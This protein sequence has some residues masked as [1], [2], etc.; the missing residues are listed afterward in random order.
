MEEYRPKLIKLSNKTKLCLACA[1]IGRK[2]QPLGELNP[3]VCWRIL[4]MKFGYKLCQIP[5]CKLGECWKEHLKQVE[6]AISMG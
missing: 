3:N 5:L 4:E 1:A 2:R 6:L